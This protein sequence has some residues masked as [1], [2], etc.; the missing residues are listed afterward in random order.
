MLLVVKLGILLGEKAIGVYYKIWFILGRVL[1]KGYICWRII[2]CMCLRKMEEL[3]N[4]MN[5]YNLMIYDLYFNDS[6]R[7]N[8][9]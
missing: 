7:C 8:G 9:Y 3:M 6:F 2:C 5:C 4:L 1:D